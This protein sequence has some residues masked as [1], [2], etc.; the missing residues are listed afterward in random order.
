MNK[1]FKYSILITLTLLMTISLVHAQSVPIGTAPQTRPYESN[2]T[3]AAPTN[4][5]TFVA[6]NEKDG[7]LGTK[8][9]LISSGTT[10]TGTL[11]LSG[12]RTPLVAQQ[13]TIAWV[14]I[15][16]KYKYPGTTG[17]TN[18]YD[19]AYKT[20][21][22]TYPALGSENLQ[23]RVTGAAAIFDK[24]G[25][26]GVRPWTNMKTY[27]GVPTPAVFTWADIANLVIRIRVAKGTSAWVDTLELYEVWLTVYETA[28]PALST[29]VSLQP[30][31]VLG[32]PIGSAF[33]VDVYMRDVTALW[34]YQFIIHYDTNVL[35]A[36]QYFSYYLFDTA[37]PSWIDD[38]KGEVSVAYTSIA[39]DVVG[40]T[41]DTPLCRIYFRVDG[42]GATKLSV[43]KSV[44]SDPVGTAISHNLYHGWFSTTIVMS[45]QPPTILLP[46]A[47]PLGTTWHELY[48]HYSNIYTLTS[49]IDQGAGDL[50]ASDQIDMLDATG[51]KY[52]FHVDQVT[53]TIHWTFKSDPE[54]PIPGEL[55]AAEPE[56]PMTE[57]PSGSPIGSKWHMIYPTYCRTIE[58]TSWTDNGG[59]GNFDPSDQFD[60]I[61]TPYD[62]LLVGPEPL[63][64]SALKF[65]DRSTIT[66]YD[67]DS[68]SA[69]SVGE[70]A[71]DD[72]DE[73]Y[74]YTPPSAEGPDV[75]LVG[76]EP[77]VGVDLAGP[78]SFDKYY[79][80]D[81]SDTWDVGEPAIRDADG[82]GTYTPAETNWAHLDSISTDIILSQ[83]GEPEPPMPEFP[84]GIG[85]VMALAPLALLAQVWRTRKK[86]MKK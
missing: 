9:D 37:A 24:G 28:P 59:I 3:V 39:A 18:G 19:M 44:L 68:D 35:T 11:L 7:K 56:T 73:D 79:D 8:V 75:L 60:F 66:F 77:D 84:F 2:P 10:A 86:V 43:D 4:L 38:S 53:I 69:W 55:G 51:W 71:I 23:P 57:M 36:E 70:P 67:A 13:F 21:G 63:K 34:G 6:G 46:G 83:K 5:P 16:I 12:F 26:A 80:A 33:F 29:T 17:S 74:V 25:L 1:H 31:A 50:D 40:F 61:Y 78:G 27:P 41:G 85:L 47:N 52:W 54:T 81:S 72:V 58:I 15:K 45:L 82:T 22:T 64:G 32:L 20:S 62:V 76:P 42:G 65:P 48:P 14:D 30:D 49:W